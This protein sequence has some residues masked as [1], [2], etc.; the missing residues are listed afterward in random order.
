MSMIVAEDQPAPF[1]QLQPDGGTA[2]DVGV[3]HTIHLHVLEERRWSG[4]TVALVTLVEALVGQRMPLIAFAT[5]TLR[6]IAA[7]PS[8]APAF[9]GI[10][11]AIAG[12]M[13]YSYDELDQ[14]AVFL[15]RSEGCQP[16]IFRARCSAAFRA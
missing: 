1:Q 10:V 5:G 3:V 12:K 7:A 13:I 9:G 16:A 11:L 2:Y 4:R 6:P 15:R 8:A 14:P